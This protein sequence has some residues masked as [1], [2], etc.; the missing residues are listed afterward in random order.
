MGMLGAAL[1]AAALLDEGAGFVF[2]TPA[3]WTRRDVDVP[4]KAVVLLPPG[5]R[6]ADATLELFPPAP[7]GPGTPEEAHERA[8]RAVS[9]QFAILTPPATGTTG[10]FR[11]TRARLAHPGGLEV[12]VAVYTAKTGP[13]TAVLVSRAADAF[14]EKHGPEVERLVQDLQFAKNAIPPTAVHGLVLPL[15]PGWTRKDDPQGAVVFT[16]PPPRTPTEPRRSYIL[17]VLP[18]QPVAVTHWAAHK[19]LFAQALQAGALPDPRAQLDVRIVPPPLEG[20][21]HRLAARGQGV[22]RRLPL[23]ER[24]GREPPPEA[25]TSG[26]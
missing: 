9:Q 10:A 8:F 13:T 17:V 21:Q 19:A 18:T 7:D 12:E 5:A 26:S 4:Q 2:T 23:L 6:V 1:L 14:F 15:G 3:G 16:P 22:G 11:R 24:L 20:R 25:S